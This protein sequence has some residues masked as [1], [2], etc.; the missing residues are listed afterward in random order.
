MEQA[1][2]Q[3]QVEALVKDLEAVVTRLTTLIVA[4][5]ISGGYRYR[6]QGKQMVAV[7]LV[8]AEVLRVAAL[9]VIVMLTGDYDDEK[10]AS[11]HAVLAAHKGNLDTIKKQPWVEGEKLTSLPLY[12][13][14]A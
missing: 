7:D 6:S 9:E 1:Q 3:A 14:N 8:E 5:E 11:W 2:A 4:G 13:L 10:Y 12:K